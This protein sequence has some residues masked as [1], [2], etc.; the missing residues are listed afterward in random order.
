MTVIRIFRQCCDVLSNSDYLFCL[1]SIDN[2][3]NFYRMA[4]FLLK[5]MGKDLHQAIKIRAVF[6][7]KTMND[8]MLEMLTEG[9]T[10]RKGEVAL[11]Q[12]EGSDVGLP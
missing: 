2:F 11:S 10:R 5:N 7:E 9:I 12:K 8:L 3:D 4:N 6:E 1:D